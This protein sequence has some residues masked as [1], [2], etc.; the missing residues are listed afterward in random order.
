MP[1]SSYGPVYIPAGSQHSGVRS[2]RCVQLVH[3]QRG[4]PTTTGRGG[5]VRA[6]CC[7]VDG[8]P[9]GLQSAGVRFV[10]GGQLVH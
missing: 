6:A 9:R 5:S 1:A 2:G 7:G 10:R 8:L 3:R 4:Q